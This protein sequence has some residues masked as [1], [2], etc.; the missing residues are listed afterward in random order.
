MPRKI[1]AYLTVGLLLLAACVYL[2]ASYGCSQKPTGDVFGEITVGDQTVVSG[3]IMFTNDQGQF[4]SSGIQNGHYLISEAPV[5]LWQVTV[6][7]VI[8]PPVADRTARLALLAKD[9]AAAKDKAEKAGKE[10]SIEAFDDPN[11]V[12][13]KYCSPRTSG[14]SFEVKPGKQK[15]DLPLDPHEKG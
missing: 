2:L 11:A 8:I 14:L 9:L 15:F 12:P 10:F 4:V 3:Q 6:Q 5:G 13:K 1:A 7:G